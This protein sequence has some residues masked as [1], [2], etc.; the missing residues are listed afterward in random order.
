[1]QGTK[2]HTDHM[3]KHTLYG[4]LTA[5]PFSVKLKIS[6]IG[7]EVLYLFF[8]GNCW[9]VLTCSKNAG[10]VMEVDD[11]RGML[12]PEPIPTIQCVWH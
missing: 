11:N 4:T 10:I 3:E 12:H 2:G 9:G 5:V 6:D 7:I 8:L 1:M